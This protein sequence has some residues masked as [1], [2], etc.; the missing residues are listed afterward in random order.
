M[1]HEFDTQ[2]WTKT[3]ATMML[4]FAQNRVHSIRE[5]KYMQGDR[6]CFLLVKAGL[7]VSQWQVRVYTHPRNMHPKCRGCK[8]NQEGRI[9]Q[10]GGGPSLINRNL[11][12]LRS[13]TYFNFRF[14][15]ICTRF[16]IYL[17]IVC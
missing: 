9:R 10:N 1:R 16:F 8:S 3:I 12:H 13:T 14:S 4:Q 17:V 5:G 6:N 2:P 7:L 11:Y 15:K